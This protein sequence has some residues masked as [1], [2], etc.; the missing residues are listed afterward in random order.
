M[1]ILCG[2]GG[3]TGELIRAIGSDVRTAENLGAAARLMDD[4]PSETLVVIGTELPSDQALAFVAATR[5]VRPAVGVVLIRDEMD[6]D[7]LSRAL[8]SGVREVVPAGELAALAAACRRSRDVSWR[9]LASASAEPGGP[10]SDGQV[11]TVFSTK[12]GV[13][14]T[15]LSV[16]LAVVLA[17][18]GGHRVCL[19][20][21]DL[22]GGD[23]ALSVLRD[24]ERT[25][26][27]AVSMAGH[28]D[29][30]GATSLLT[31]YQPGLDLVL[32]PLTPGDA[33]K[34]PASLVGEL[35]AVLR[36]MFDFVVV[37]TTPQ[38]SEHVLTA[39]DASAHH[40]LVTTPDVLALKG[41]R[42]ALDVLDML[43]YPADIRSVV[44]NRAD[45][46][47][48]LDVKD[49]ERVLRTPVA[50]QVP[51]NHAVQTAVNSGSPVALAS[52]KN[53]V[54]KAIAK[55]AQQRLL[56]APAERAGLLASLTRRQS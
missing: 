39:L 51:D 31:A 8:Q 32:A 37:D 35:L 40:V 21:L 14:K 18:A 23:V 11:I 15:M 1:P 29:V 33:E 44:L 12:G 24:P 26:T 7:V 46:R 56:P 36:G 13:G 25:L 48:K 45:S 41:L 55:F 54:S 50:A 17:R 28:L 43:S 10:R 53:P 9:V 47:A 20:D 4:D 5:T 52:P 34:I 19:V 38:F 42:V 16:N 30:T 22:A 2:A 6:V 49:A 27:D 3:D